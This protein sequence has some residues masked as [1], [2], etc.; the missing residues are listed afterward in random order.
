MDRSDSAPQEKRRKLDYPPTLEYGTGK[1]VRWISRNYLPLKEDATQE[2]IPQLQIIIT[3]SEVEKIVGYM[4]DQLNKTFEGAEEPVLLVGV[5]NGVCFFFSHLMKKLHIRY[6][7]TFVK[8]SS[9]GTAMAGE[10]K[11]ESA[12]VVLDEKLMSPTRKVVVLDELEDQGQTMNLV[13]SKLMSLG[14][15]QENLT[16]AVLFSKNKAAKNG[17]R[18]CD[19]I[20]IGVP[21]LWLVG[22]GLDHRRGKRGWAHV[23][24]I[25][26]DEGIPRSEDDDVFAK[27]PAVHEKAFVNMR[28][29]IVA[30]LKEKGL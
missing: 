3:E 25:A 19:I 6:E 11:K 12:C 23:H 21:D 5:L 14:V 20:G 18:P 27:D 10:K 4:A 24:A 2:E 7:I 29:K 30:Q 13:L 1:D 8:M 15:K 9:Y 22:W 16:G 26:K 17:Y 28:T